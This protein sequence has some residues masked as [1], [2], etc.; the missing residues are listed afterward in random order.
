[1]IRQR[2]LAALILILFPIVVQAQQGPLELTSPLGRK[3]YA[4]P[5]DSAIAAA[6]SAL[7]TEP[8]SAQKALKL[9]LALAGRRQYV[10]AVAADTAALNL[11][12][13]DATPVAGARPPP[14]WP[15]PVR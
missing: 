8:K 10:E 7:A 15:A 9:S 6:K 2:T 4:L 14:A 5:A 13:S 3:L 12:P 11:N 1:M